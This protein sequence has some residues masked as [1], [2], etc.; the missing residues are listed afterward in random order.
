MHADIILKSNL[1][2]NG[3]DRK[4]IDGGVILCSQGV[5][6]QPYHLM[7]TT[8]PYAIIA[9]GITKILYLTVGFFIM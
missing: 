3:L 5:G 6:I 7:T 9:G 4:V 8:L 1:I 2:Y